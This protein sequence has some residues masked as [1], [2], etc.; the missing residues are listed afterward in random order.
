[1]KKKK[2]FTALISAVL[3]LSMVFP[4][5]GCTEDKLSE[6][7][8][9]FYSVYNTYKVKQDEMPADKEILPADSLEITMVQGEYELLQLIM[10][11]SKDVEWYNATISDLVNVADSNEVYESENVVVS[12]Q[13]YMYI[14]SIRAKGAVQWTGYTPGY[15]PDALIPM[16][17][18]VNYGE[19]K[20]KAGDNQGLTFQF[21]TRPKLENDIPV[22][23]T[24]I[25]EEQAK[26]M[27]DQEKYTYNKPGTYKGTITLDFKT[28]KKE[29]PVTLN[30]ASATVSE[31]VHTKADFGQRTYK[32]NAELNY[33][34]DAQD[35]WNASIVK[36]RHMS[37]RIYTEQSGSQRDKDAR[38][39]IAKE[40]L[41]RDRVNNW[42]FVATQDDFALNFSEDNE[43][44][45]QNAKLNGVTS[46]RAEPTLQE[47]D[48][49]VKTSIE[50]RFNYVRKLTLKVNCVDEP[51]SHN[52]WPCVE[53]SGRTL[54]KM[55]EVYTEL[56]EN[57]TYY[58]GEKIKWDG[59]TAE[60]KEAFKAELMKSI[61]DIQMPVSESYNPEYAPYVSCWVPQTGAYATPTQR[62]NYANDDERWWFE[63]VHDI[64]G[65][66]IP[67]RAMGWM[68][69]EFDIVGQMDWAIDCFYDTS[70][71]GRML[72]EFYSNYFPRSSYGNGDG[73]YFYPAGQYELDELVP[74]FR[75]QA[76]LDAFEEWELFYNIKQIYAQI[77]EEAD[78]EVDATGVIAGLGSNIY[79]GSTA[80]QDCANFEM[81]R[82]ALINLSKCTESSARFCI[83]NV[84]EDGFGK[85][86]YTI[87]LANDNGQPRT[88]KNHG[89]I[90]Q[91]KEAVTGGNLYEIVI[92]R[93]QKSDNS[94]S[95]E[96]VAD[97]ETMVYTQGVGGKMTIVEVEDIK[98]N[99]FKAATTDVYAQ[100]VD[101]IQTWDENHNPIDLTGLER[102]DKDLKI[103][104]YGA[105]AFEDGAEYINIFVQSEKLNS[106]FSG[107]VAQMVVHFHNPTDKVINISATGQIENQPIWASLF[108]ADLKP[109]YN[110]ITLSMAGANWSKNKL[111]KMKWSFKNADGTHMYSNE[112]I[113]IK[114]IIVY[115]K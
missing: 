112:T 38:H 49:W 16:H 33:T 52:R 17:A 21:S 106:L 104:V 60:E 5:I 9:Y 89:D 37:N 66:L 82:R 102:G 81:T 50:D 18:I 94:I 72:D 111:V 34:Q 101:T 67:E 25:S 15:Y 23:K 70:N 43:W 108:N 2:L 20:I 115:E 8:F 93:T 83:A 87:Y 3:T 14:G 53:A 39:A 27:S 59:Y 107:N 84:K 110:A 80:I 75:M 109:G 40:L 48:Y 41:K 98:A 73:W 55:V 88:L 90:V 105:D 19:N 22:L 45:K 24:G 28:F 69:A 6:K 64:E 85:V 113:Y 4:F 57:D 91:P 12:K 96:F 95:L 103:D 100:L 51:A 35:M 78:I 97:G 86:T 7:D 76:R 56:M 99:S 31:T 63:F 29:I 44:H 10:K 58:N 79:A 26:T 46:L 74:S 77:A 1:M 61:E 54:Q 11:P 62:A 30:I 68:A 36:Y 42:A 71:G 92:D 65:N 32:Y 13:E 114:D 47:Y